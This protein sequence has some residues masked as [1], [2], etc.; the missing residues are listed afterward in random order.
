MRIEK[1]R[2]QY[3]IRL[4]YTLFPL[5]PETPAG[6]ISLEEMFKGRDFDLKAAKLNFQKLFSQEGLDYGDREITYNSRLAQEM[7]KWAESLPGG[8]KIHDALYRAYFVDVVNIAD[9][10]NLVAV[11]ASIGLDPDQARSV[12]KN[13]KYKDSVDE[14][15]RKC[16]S[17]GVN[18]VPTYFCDGRAL[19]GAQSYE[20]LTKLVVAAGAEPRLV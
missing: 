7:G 15:W 2:Q 4:S 6:G 18:A 17:I 19:V 8:Q 5:H 10:E 13:R 1:L 12:I 9:I 11:A 3:N 20:N 14:D 16:W